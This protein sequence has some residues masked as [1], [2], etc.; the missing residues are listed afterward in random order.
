[1]ENKYLNDQLF[2]SV[3]H[4]LSSIL[5]IADKESN[6]CIKFY[7]IDKTGI[8]YTIGNVPRS[9]R[10]ICS[11]DL[12]ISTNIEKSFFDVSIAQ[13]ILDIDLFY[14]MQQRLPKGEIPLISKTHKKLLDFLE[15]I[16]FFKDQFNKKI[17]IMI[18]NDD[19]ELIKFFYEDVDTT[20]L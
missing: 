14:R 7:G 8:Y 11:S 4:H 16:P 15:E 1:M 10:R 13:F 6:Q 12:T 18:E 19:D 20:Y 9:I 3:E 5:N 2:Y 17:K